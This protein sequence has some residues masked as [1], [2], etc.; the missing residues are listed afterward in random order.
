MKYVIFFLLC[1]AQEI[2]LP[3]P[4]V[5]T[6]VFGIATIGNLSTFVLAL[7]GILLGICLMYQFVFL[8][9]RKYLK[10]YEHNPKYLAYQK[11]VSK[12]PF[13]T[14]GILFAIPILPDE[15]ILVGSALANISLKMILGI[16]LFSKTF[17]IGVLVFSSTVAKNLEI[18]EWQ[19]MA[20][21][22]M[23]MLLAAL[24]YQKWQEKN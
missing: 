19:V 3:L 13:L 7:L 14:T 11:Y 9:K 12:N 23:I 15:I 5:S 4:E 10:K 20:I 22:I 1:V 17:S 24:F 18:S 8:F 2:C 16:A 6:V 21:T